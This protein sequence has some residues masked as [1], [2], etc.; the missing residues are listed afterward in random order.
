MLDKA[1]LRRFFDQVDES[2]DDSLA[3][4]VAVI[5]KHMRSFPK[6]SEALADGRYMLRHLRRELLERQFRP[7]KSV[8]D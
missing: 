6:G 2:S 4:K 7:G 3:D 5:E 8:S 1:F